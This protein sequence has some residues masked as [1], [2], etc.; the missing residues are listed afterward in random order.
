M[1]WILLCVLQ[2]TL[3]E[4]YSSELFGK[5]L[6]MVTGV[7]N[8]KTGKQSGEAVPSMDKDWLKNGVTFCLH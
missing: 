3:P 4:N 7:R 6:H 2:Q 1:L 8:R 5:Y